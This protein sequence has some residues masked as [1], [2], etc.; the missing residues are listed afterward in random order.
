M[1]GETA[2]IYIYIYIYLFK[3]L[4]TVC[5][6]LYFCFV[7]NIYSFLIHI[8]SSPCMVCGVCHVPED[9]EIIVPK[10]VGTM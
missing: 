9:G 2:I 5:V 8:G 6:C 4:R 1:F 3:L 10:H 7:F